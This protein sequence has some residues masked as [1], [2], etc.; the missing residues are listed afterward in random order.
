MKLIHE[1]KVKKV[2]QDPGSTDRVVIEFTDTVTAGD[3]EKKEEIEGKGELACRMTEYLLGYLEGKGIDTHFV[4]PLD[5]PQM[6]ARKVDIYPMEVVCRNIAAGSFCRRYGVEKGTV[7]EKPLV[8]F[9][10]KDDNLHDPLITP[11]AIISLGLVS[12]KNLQFMRSVTLSSNY[13]LVELLK[14]QGLTLVDFKLEFGCTEAGHIVIADELSGDTMRVW[15][16]K[17]KSLDKDVFREDKGDLIEVYSK[18][19]DSLL[20]AKPEDVSNRNE[21]IQ[22]V[23]QPKSGIKN[24]PGEVTKKAL[25]RL[26]FGEA[27]EVRVGK[28]FNILLQKPVTSEILNQLSIMNIKL[29]SNPISEKHEV[30]LD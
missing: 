14:Q 30:S 21:M 16:E 1:G 25:I 10:V 23:V 26:G 4:K 28:I 27:E 8:E 18:L 20:S 12:D 3:G 29:L 19:V 24:P 15:D 7:L 11:E 22:V 2:F 17:S 5:G 13:Y 6:L 9:F